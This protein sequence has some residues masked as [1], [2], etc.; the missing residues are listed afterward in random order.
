MWQYAATGPGPGVTLSA[1]QGRWHQS[2][3]LDSYLHGGLILNS[4]NA[5]IL[6]ILHKIK[7]EFIKCVS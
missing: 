5:E 3:M 7:A 2:T 4:Y 6:Q 1:V